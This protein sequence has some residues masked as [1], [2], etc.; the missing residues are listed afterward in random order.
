MNDK[1]EYRETLDDIDGAIFLSKMLFNNSL[2][3][4]WD[5]LMM[6]MHQ[7]MLWC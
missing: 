4:I 1:A 5:R 2:V 6:M 3:H 7:M